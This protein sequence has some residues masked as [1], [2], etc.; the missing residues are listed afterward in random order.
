M[1]FESLYDSI[2]QDPV[3]T[4]HLYTPVLVILALFFAMC[5]LLPCYTEQRGLTILFVNYV[6]SVITLDLMLH[7]MAGKSFSIVQPVI[8]LLVVPFIAHYLNLPSEVQRMIPVA[9]TI[10]T[11]L[12][13]MGKMTIISR[14]WL[15]YSQKYFWTIKQQE[16]DVKKVN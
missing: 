11:W 15:D 6:L 2:K 13:F 5:S 14:Q 7:N 8:L 10:L 3:R 12:I 1:I 4:L 9:L 16:I